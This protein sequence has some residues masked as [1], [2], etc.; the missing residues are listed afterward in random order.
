MEV[1]PPSPLCTSDSP[2]CDFNLRASHAR[3]LLPAALASV[4]RHKTIP[5]AICAVIVIV[6]ETMPCW[7]KNSPEKC[8][9]DLG[10]DTRTSTHSR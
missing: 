4:S 6:V 9:V 5:Y 1:L 2:I 3:A 8:L 10:R 7:G